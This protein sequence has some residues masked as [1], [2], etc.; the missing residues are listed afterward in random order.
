MLKE[1]IE[2]KWIDVLVD[3]F[4]H[5]KVEQGE[6]AAILSESQSREVLVELSELALA[7]LGARV[8]HV[9]LPSPPLESSVPI[10][11]TGTCLTI[12]GLEPVI[13]ALAQSGI[14][15]DCTVEGMLHARELPQLLKGGARLMMLSDEHPE[16]FERLRPV[17][18]LT[19]K[20]RL[21]AHVLSDATRM[22]VTSSAGSAL[23]VDITDTPGRG[24]AGIAA[25]PGSVGYWPA[26]LCLCFPKTGSANGQLVLAPGDVNLT[27]KRYLETPVTLT[28]EDG[29][30]VD[31]AGDDLDADLM[32]S[33]YAAWNEKDAYAVSHV[34]WGMN[35]Q[36]R[37][38]ALVMYDRGDVNGTELRAFAGNFLFSTG[39]NQ[40][41][42][43]YSACHF[44]IPM[45]GCTVEL[46]GQAVVK[47][48]E[49]Q[50]ELVLE[51]P[52]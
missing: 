52:N 27:F 38:D 31:I 22:R 20:C 16:V 4:E 33:Y 15:I 24:S 39:A 30:V 14:I 13:A 10:R 48:G 47:N 42:G 46:D 37:W 29:F 12:D 32:R 40:E 1:R 34:G 44:D 6:V 35:P 51:T 45:R 19:E 49:L 18:G 21:G 36:A 8:F 25:K 17:P 3:L 23:E 26:G 7:R 9:R 5:C 41:S 28:L 11:S 50:G 2:S 43:R